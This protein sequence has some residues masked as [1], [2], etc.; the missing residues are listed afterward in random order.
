V[1]DKAV[2]MRTLEY[3]AK[4]CQTAAARAAAAEI[5]AGRAEAEAA[6][7]E[8]SYRRLRNRPLVRA[9]AA[10]VRPIRR[11]RRG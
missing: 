5:R 8:R 9:A 4:S 3:V 6:K 11:R 7:W 1:L 2:R 10:V